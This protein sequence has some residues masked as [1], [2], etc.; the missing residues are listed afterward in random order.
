MFLFF[1]LPLWGLILWCAYRLYRDMR[2]E[3]IRYIRLIRATDAE[4]GVGMLNRKNVRW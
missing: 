2:T 4:F 3:Y 1:T